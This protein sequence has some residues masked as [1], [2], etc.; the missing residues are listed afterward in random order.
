[1]TKS[2][3]FDKRIDKQY[4]YH[5][6]LFA[7]GLL[8]LVACKQ[9]THDELSGHWRML[10]LT[11]VSPNGGRA[12][13]ITVPSDIEVDVYYNFKKDQTFRGESS[14]STTTG[15]WSTESSQKYLLLKHGKGSDTL[16]K[17]VQGKEMLLESVIRT[18][19]GLLKIGYQKVL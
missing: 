14:H 7:F 9:E 11:R 15:T 18:D 5:I 19:K 16:W 10:T 3:L 1:M 6:K 2:R 13:K 8:W 4:T 12:E 17:I